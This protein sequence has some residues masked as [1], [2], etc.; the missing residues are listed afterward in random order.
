MAEHIK[1]GKFSFGRLLQPLADEYCEGN[2]SA[3]AA[4]VGYHNSRFRQ[5]SYGNRHLSGH[6]LYSL[7]TNLDLKD[8]TQ[9]VNLCFAHQ[10]DLTIAERRNLRY[11]IVSPE[12]YKKMV[13]QGKPLVR[14]DVSREHRKKN[15]GE[16]TNVLYS[17][18]FTAAAQQHPVGSSEYFD[19]IRESLRHELRSSPTTTSKRLTEI[20]R[21]VVATE[22][23]NCHTLDTMR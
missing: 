8:E 1:Q 16:P 23:G 3:L 6:A 21:H 14:W 7:I 11:Q 4:R 19:V 5:V 9:V 17:A 22:N 10:D 2:M 12:E 18:I 20:E 15:A 13:N